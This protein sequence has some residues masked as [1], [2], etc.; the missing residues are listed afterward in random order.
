MIKPVEKKSAGARGATEERI[1]PSARKSFHLLFLFPPDETPHSSAILLLSGRQIPE[2]H[3]ERHIITS[4]TV[5]ICDILLYIVNVWIP[6]SL[7]QPV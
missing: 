4:V 2:S 6:T 5:T 7:H 3:L 1:I